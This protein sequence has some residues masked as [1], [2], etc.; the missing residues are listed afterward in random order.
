M[1]VSHSQ[2]PLKI[3]EL[4]HALGVEIGS[5]DMNTDNVPSIRTVLGCCQGLVAIDEGSSTSRLAHFTVKEYLSNHPHL[6]DRPHSKIAETCLTYLNFQAIK[7]LSNLCKNTP[8]HIF[9]LIL[10]NPRGHGALRP[11][12][13]PRA[14]PSFSIP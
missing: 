6:F 5:T 2:R 14:R 4:C 3:Y 7:D 8:T 1:W 11:L 10:G 12:K 9:I 13:A